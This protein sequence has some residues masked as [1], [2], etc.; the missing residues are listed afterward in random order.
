MIGMLIYRAM[1][2][3]LP[4][5]REIKQILGDPRPTQKGR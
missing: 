4:L 2:T 3:S 5:E 1:Y